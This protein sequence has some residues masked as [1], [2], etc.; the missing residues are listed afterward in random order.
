MK[1]SNKLNNII[2]CIKESKLF[3]DN[4]C[5]DIIYKNTICENKNSY[6]N[7]YTVVINGNYNNKEYIFKFYNNILDNFYYN[8]INFLMYLQNFN[9]VPKIYDFYEGFY[10]SIVMEK[11]DGDVEN[12]LYDLMQ[13][14]S[15]DLIK[16][17]IQKIIL[18]ILLLNKEYGVLHNDMKFNNILYNNINDNYN[19]VFIDFSF[20][21]IIKSV[22][23]PMFIDIY[24]DDINYDNYHNDDN[25]NNW[26][27]TKM[28]RFFVYK[29]A[30]GKTDDIK[31][32][33]I[34]LKR[35]CINKNVD[36]MMFSDFFL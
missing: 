13:N 30:I 25:Y 4:L 19:F 27:G 2:L 8:E 34:D 16:Y 3:V 31:C 29:D 36:F 12:L 14:K 5:G 11:Y 28:D 10:F 20:S 22:N 1:S 33:Y 24:N 26:I 7:I 18:K 21:H 23:S 15:F 17:I 6:A 35:I 32:L 9:I